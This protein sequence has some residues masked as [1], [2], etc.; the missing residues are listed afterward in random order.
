M[1]GAVSPEVRARADV[2]GF[3][4][5][6]AMFERRMLCAFN[7]YLVRICELV[8][9]DLCCLCKQH[10]SAYLVSWEI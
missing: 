4:L 1:I 3:S 2:V 9:E 10:T 7:F 8:L 6:R 5:G